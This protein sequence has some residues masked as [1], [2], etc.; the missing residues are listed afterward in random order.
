[1]M[2]PELERRK[3][4]QIAKALQELRKNM[5]GPDADV[6]IKTV[7]LVIETRMQT[8]RVMEALMK[9][10]IDGSIARAVRSRLS[11]LTLEYDKLIQEIDKL[12]AQQ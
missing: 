7:A 4:E 6:R 3:R 9:P 2:S 11:K 10:H 8:N 5:H 12:N 1:M